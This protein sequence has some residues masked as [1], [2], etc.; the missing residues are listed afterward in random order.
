MNAKRIKRA[1]IVLINTLLVLVIVGI[2]LATWMPAIYTS[3]W[4]HHRFP[5]W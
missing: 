2:I 3:E 4:F 1:M 5:K